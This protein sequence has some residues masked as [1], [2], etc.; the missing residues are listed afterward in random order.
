M[1]AEDIFEL[2]PFYPA[3]EDEGGGLLAVNLDEAV[4]RFVRERGELVARLRD[5]PPEAWERPGR[6]PEYALYNVFGLARHIVLH[7]L[8]HGY[9]IEDSL[10]LQECP[11][12][13]A[14]P[15]VEPPAV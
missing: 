13:E 3:P 1:L 6:H 10:R 2:E 4:E 9:R 14:P 5:L 12:H 7:D 15:H 11:Q 8:L